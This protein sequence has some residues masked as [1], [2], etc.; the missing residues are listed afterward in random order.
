MTTL[1]FVIGF[2]DFCVFDRLEFSSISILACEKMAFD[3]RL[4]KNTTH[5]KIG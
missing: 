2:Q 5:K 1:G 3:Q 4:N